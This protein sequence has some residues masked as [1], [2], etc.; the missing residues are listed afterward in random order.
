MIQP[1]NDLVTI[2]EYNCQGMRKALVHKKKRELSMS[3][4]T[5]QPTNLDPLKSPTATK[6]KSDTLIPDSTDYT[7]P[8]AKNDPRL[9]ELAQM[10]AALRTR[11]RTASASS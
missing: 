2:E 7:D 1:C 10:V 11:R 4:N 8:S 9:Q 3:T 6:G 5:T